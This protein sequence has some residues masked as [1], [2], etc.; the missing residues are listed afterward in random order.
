MIR[1]ILLSIVAFLLAAPSFA[2][3]IGVSLQRHPSGGVDAASAEVVAVSAGDVTKKIRS[4]LPGKLDLPAGEWF[5]EVHAGDDWSETRLITVRDNQPQTVELSSYRA[6]RLEARAAL[7]GGKPPVE[8]KV[9]F[10]RARLGDEDTPVE[11]SVACDIARGVATCRLPAG[12]LD[13]SFRVIGY[14]SRFRWGV[15][16][17][18]GATFDSGS[19]GFVPG[20]TLSGRV[21]VPKGH[22]A[23]IDRVA[24]VAR[25]VSPPGSKSKSAAPMPPRSQPSPTRAASS[26]S[27]CRP[28]NSRCRLR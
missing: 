28:V 6:A 5:L 16:L 27:I 10:Q 20:S 19:I 1:R 9:S 22:E 13:L 15:K 14:A 25:P 26:P 23:Q 2:V 4:S 7:P 24:I 18:P 12:E 21:E 11:G 17:S 8:M 3:E